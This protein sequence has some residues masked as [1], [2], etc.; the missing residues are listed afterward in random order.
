MANLNYFINGTSV[1]VPY[2]AISVGSYSLTP[3]PP[4]YIKSIQVTRISNSAVS[5][6]SNQT[7]KFTINLVNS[8]NTFNF[9]DDK[10]TF[11]LSYLMSEMSN[12]D[13]TTSIS[14]VYG[15]T[16]GVKMHVKNGVVSSFDSNFDLDSNDSI[17]NYTISGACSYACVESMQKYMSNDIK[18]SVK[19]IYSQSDITN[20]NLEDDLDGDGRITMTDYTKLY[21][22]FERSEDAY[23]TLSGSSFTSLSS[24]R[25][26]GYNEYRWSNMIEVLAKYIFG[27]YYDHIE[28]EHTDR[29]YDSNYNLNNANIF[30]NLN[31]SSM[32]LGQVL[33]AMIN[34]CYKWL[35]DE[36]PPELKKSGNY[37]KLN[38]QS[39][40]V[41]ENNSVFADNPL[42]SSRITSV[43]MLN[44]Q[45]VKY[46][47]DGQSLT[48]TAG[49][50][51]YF[52]VKYVT[53]GTNGDQ[54]QISIDDVNSRIRIGTNLESSVI[55]TYTISNNN[56]NSDV[57]SFSISSNGIPAIAAINAA[58]SGSS[59]TIKV[60]DG[61]ILISNSDTGGMVALDDIK[62]D[63]FVSKF[64][65]E[66][67]DSIANNTSAA[68][69]TVLGS[70]RS[71]RLGLTDVI[72]VIPQ[73][74]GGDTFWCGD[75]NIMSI[76][77]TVDESGYRISFGLTFNKSKM[78]S[79]FNAASKNM[80]AQTVN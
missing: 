35:A 46:S 1:D 61:Q 8:V 33:M 69:L 37:V 9:G 16:N 57:L 34:N 79:D 21:N 43:S 12:T 71:C 27:D 80:K 38:G 62:M 74:N 28:V 14:M 7:S 25:K 65:N 51:N 78:H 18:I 36:D 6:N 44:M 4:K 22:A 40:I 17:V 73:I 23:I 45:N 50:K 67:A 47:D 68:T 76:T 56:K 32:T 2:L 42:G 5:E 26:F 39:Y 64:K 75:Y 20:R 52:G 31:L 10:L 55:N 19:D 13:S 66:L 54:Y 15:W 63:A 58:K 53:H 41:F 24:L 48:F 11:I 3:I 49:G 60:D 77:D 72:R 29:V 59:A 30:S 70:N